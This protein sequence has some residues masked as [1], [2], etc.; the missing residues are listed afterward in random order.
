MLVPLGPKLSDNEDQV[1]E[2]IIE[3]IKP[4]LKI[5]QCPNT[6]SNPGDWFMFLLTSAKSHLKVA[7]NPQYF[8][9]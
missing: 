2:H 5:R 6:R 3:L 4:N 7:H 8:Q 1:Y 9:G